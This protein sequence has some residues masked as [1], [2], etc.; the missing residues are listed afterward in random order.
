VITVPKAG[1]T[2]VTSPAWETVGEQKAARRGDQVIRPIAYGLTGLILGA[3]LLQWVEVARNL[4]QVASLVGQDLVYYTNRTTHWLATGELYWPWQLAGPYEFGWSL[5][6]IYPPNTLLLF[7]PFVILPACF[8][9]AIPISLTLWAI[10]RL[11]P[12]P[13]AWPVM[14]LCLWVPSSIT[15]LWYGRSDM[16]AVALLSLGCVYGW[17]AILLALKPTF[18]LFALV[19][20]RRPSWWIVGLGLAGASLLFGRLWFDYLTAIQNLRGISPLSYS[21]HAVPAMLIPITAWVARR[22]P[23]PETDPAADMR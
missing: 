9:W 10:W 2:D 1:Q 8:W 23:S 11:R 15:I 16:W 22:A 7:L 4:D 12:T 13:I 18:L 6:V 14:A 19:G 20:I 21:L 17:P 5:D 3:W